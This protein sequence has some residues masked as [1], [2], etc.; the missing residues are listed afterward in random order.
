MRIS[1]R[2]ASLMAVTL[3]LTGCGA[4]S[5]APNTS[6]ST[7]TT[8]S[9]VVAQAFQSLLYLPL[10]VGIDKGF[11][12]QHGLNVTKVT[13]NSGSNAVASVISGSAQFSLQDPM[14]AM[15]SDI[16]G[17]QIIPIAAVVNGV[18]VWI[19]GKSGHTLNS[20]AGQTVAT[21]IPPSTSTYLLE[22]ALK[23]NHLTAHLD[24]VQL[25]TEAA[26][27][28]AGKAQY[29]AVYEPTV[30]DAVAQGLKIVYSFAHQYEGNY[31]FS[32]IDA[33]STFLHNHPQTVQAFVDGLEE[34]LQYIAHHP[35]GTIQVALKEFPSLPPSVV[36]AGVAR[37]IRDKV[38]A[39][40]PVISST[41]FQN[42]LSLQ[43]FLGNIHP[44][45]VSYTTDVN[46]TF[47]VKATES[48]K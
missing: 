14:I 30:E 48:T 47:A 45:Q 4:S 40:S 34:S 9:I 24:F 31:A 46:T 17:A 16:K 1:H 33:N 21:A 3:W 13:S 42:A 19:V 15:L 28:L 35:H 32:S 41:A 2:V 36:K 8:K 25:G 26:P 43:E 11:F 20:I 29:A 6:S 18:P 44:G 37:M 12:A 22:R 10:Y 38:Y 27:V 23:Q 5:A 39:T 7:S